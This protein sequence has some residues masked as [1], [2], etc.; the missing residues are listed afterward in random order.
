L[1]Y[2][3]EKQ[4][5]YKEKCAKMKWKYKEPKKEEKKK[6]CENP[7]NKLELR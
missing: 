6:P 3:F 4:E 5:S 7:T 2:N 1:T